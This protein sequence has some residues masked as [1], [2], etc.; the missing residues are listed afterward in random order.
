MARFPWTLANQIEATAEGVT[1]AVKLPTWIGWPFGRLNEHATAL[2]YICMWYALLEARINHLIQCQLN[3]TD[4]TGAAIASATGNSILPRCKLVM[5]LALE[6]RVSDEWHARLETVLRKV[7]Q[8]IAPE[9]NRLVHDDW[10]PLREEA[11]QIDKRPKIKEGQ[12]SIK[13]ERRR[14]LAAMWKL[15]A[16]IQMAEK[17]LAEVGIEYINWARYNRPWGVG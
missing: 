2:G 12:L 9:R 7:E 8:E 5:Q 15:V 17:E 11:L 16:H 1:V 10:I 13:T 3:A 4:Q 6:R 14:E